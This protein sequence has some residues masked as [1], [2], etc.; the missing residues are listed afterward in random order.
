MEK[1]KKKSKNK[2]SLFS[3]FLK[4]LWQYR[5]VT[6][7]FVLSFLVSGF[8]FTLYGSALEAVFYSCTV[9]LAMFIVAGT[10]RFVH[11]VKKHRERKKAL[12]NIMVLG[13][14]LPPAETSLEEDY[15][16]MLLAL[17]RMLDAEITK[18]DSVLQENIEYYTTWVHQIKTPISVMQMILQGEDTEEH[19][20][21]SSQLFKIEQ[22]VEMVLNYIRLGG[23]SDF[24]FKEYELD[25]IIKQAVHKFAPQFI[26]KHI[27]LRYEAVDIKVI[28]DEKWFS[29][30]LEQLLSNAVKYTE[31]GQVTIFVTEDR[32]LKISDTG[33]GIAKEDLPRIFEKGFTGYN[34][35]ENKKSTGL[36]LYLCKLTADRLSHKIYAESEAGRG[37]VFSVDLNRYDLKAE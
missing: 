16:E 13:S 4:F 19:R 27:G 36:G 10:A 28:T 29:F 30:M 2:D 34:G 7:L 17:R 6:V 3:V 31:K 37:S 8:I 14:E 23:S 26:R 15:M 25:K 1:K 20:E 21:L 22:Y 24:V 12:E 11:Y 33:I 5:Y 35:R 9:C 32:L 18:K